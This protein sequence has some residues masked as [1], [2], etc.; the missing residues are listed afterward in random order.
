[1][2]SQFFTRAKSNEGINLKLNLPDGTPTKYWIR[3]RGVDSDAYKKAIADMRAR[4]MALMGS[5]DADDQAKLKS[6]SKGQVHEDELLN[7]HV[8]LVADW[9]ME[10][11]NEKPL[12]CTPEEVK[13]FLREAPQIAD[14][15]NELSTRRK[16]FFGKSLKG[17]T[18]SHELN[19]S[20]HSPSPEATPAP[21]N[22]S[23]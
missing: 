12:P 2:K 20:S 16:L 22:A 23:T 13:K 1:M 18:P 9:N 17:S 6:M 5:E 11:D 3:I 19:S 15:I 7:I 10:D 14:Q 21:A 8:A 4:A